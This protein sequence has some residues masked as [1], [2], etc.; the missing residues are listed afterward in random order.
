ML[1]ASIPI[2]R[3]GASRYKVQAVKAWCRAILDCQRKRL[4]L[5]SP[6][7]AALWDGYVRAA[8]A[9]WRSIR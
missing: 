9:C 5:E 4:T 3:G 2:A 7:D 8:R 1:H 6:G